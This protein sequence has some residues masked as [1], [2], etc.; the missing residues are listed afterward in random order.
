MK[1]K[2]MIL[3]AMAVILLFAFTAACYA[4]DAQ[5]LYVAGVKKIQ[6]RQFEKAI[7][8]FEKA[9]GLNKGFV[10]AYVGKGL[11]YFMLDNHKKA[12]EDFNMAIQRDPENA[13]A[14]FWR[15][16]SY[17]MAGDSKSAIPDFSGV[18]RKQPENAYSHLFK[19][20]A[21]F[22]IA[23][24]DDA[25]SDVS[26]S[27]SANPRKAEPYVI[28]GLCYWKKK[29]YDSAVRDFKRGIEIDPS[30]AYYQLL[31][32]TAKAINGDPSTDDLAK[33][34]G[35]DA[36]KKDKMVYQ[37]IGMM[38][39]KVTTDECLKTAEKSE[40]AKLRGTMI[41]QAQFFVS[42]YYQ[43]KGDKE[44]SKKYLDLAEKGEN[45]LFVMAAIMKMVFYELKGTLEAK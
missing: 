29:S 11:C 45:K 21:S 12:I 24:L 3:T 42:S 32:Y 9:I 37:L 23:K 10:K 16:A 36:A 19:G 6:D 20:I 22:R 27:I 34:Y 31:A 14:L 28:R 5:T 25:I 17:L 41:Q 30:N 26:K 18:L 35:Q 40:P 15:G 13:T 38:L 8:D 7:K 39:G 33:F 4:E 43:I 1:R 44:K 2:A